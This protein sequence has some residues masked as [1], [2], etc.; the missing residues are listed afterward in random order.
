MPCH[1][2]QPVVE[3]CADSDK[4]HIQFRDLQGVNSLI[5]SKDVGHIDMI[6]TLA[7]KGVM[8]GPRRLRLSARAAVAVSMTFLRRK[9]P[10]MPSPSSPKPMHWYA[11]SSEAMCVRTVHCSSYFARAASPGLRHIARTGITTH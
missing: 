9:T 1:S 4:S 3:L 10:R 2:G 7:E 5:W 8:R 11:L 6:S